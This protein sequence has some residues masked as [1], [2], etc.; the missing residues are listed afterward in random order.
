SSLDFMDV[1][2]FVATKLAEGTLGPKKTRD[3]VSVIS[4]VMQAAIR[5]GARRDNPAAG[6][7]VPV[8]RRR[9]RQGDVL[10]M[11][12]VHALIDQVR[13]PYKPAVWLLVLTGMRPAELAGSGCGRSTLFVAWSASGRRSSPS[14]RTQ[15]S[16]WHSSPA[17]PR[18]KQATERS[19]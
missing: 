8:R 1:E 16:A 11:T 9:I 6:H 12:E 7:H 2:R 4:L 10:T 14:R 17:R 15:T 19:R 5:S 18:Q 13:D 3:C